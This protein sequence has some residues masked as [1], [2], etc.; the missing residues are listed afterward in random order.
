[1]KDKSPYMYSSDVKIGDRI[2]YSTDA[3][4]EG[5]RIAQVY[6]VI[7]FDKK[8]VVCRGT[9]AKQYVLPERKPG[10]KWTILTA[11]RKENI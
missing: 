5:M 4:K 7:G 8:G 3:F 1:M 9:D 6:Q 2:V 11:S 10:E